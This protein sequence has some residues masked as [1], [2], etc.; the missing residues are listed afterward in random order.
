MQILLGLAFATA[1]T[2]AAQ[3]LNPQ[4][5]LVTRFMA[6]SGIQQFLLLNKKTGYLYAVA[7][8][9]IRH[10]VPALSGKVK[11]DD[12]IHPAVTKADIFMLSPSPYQDR[13]DASITFLERPGYN[14]TIHRLANVPGER[15][16][17]RLD[18]KTPDD[19]F[20]TNGCV[21]LDSKDYDAISKFVSTAWQTATS[22]DGKA[23]MTQRWMVV[24]P[25]TNDLQATW[26]YFNMPESLK[27]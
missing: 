9:E 27:P 6:S 8:G 18:S 10:R 20:I 17:Q 13:P 26:Q 4:E 5:H 7:D 2:A 12:S 21:N 22:A 15:R 3:P 1:N 16:R 25:Q 19:N 24:L 14:L 11:G 23:S